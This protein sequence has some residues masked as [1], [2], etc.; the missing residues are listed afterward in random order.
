M[1]I[2]IR[3]LAIGVILVVSMGNADF[4]TS[5]YP[6][7]GDPSPFT[8][9]SADIDK[10]GDLDLAI[11]NWNTGVW[12]FKN[13]GTGNFSHDGTIP[14]GSKSYFIS[15]FDA[16]KDG[17]VDLAVA[18]YGSGDVYVLLNDGTGKYPAN[19][20]DQL[21]ALATVTSV[22]GVDLNN[23]SIVD[24]VATS[25]GT[26]NVITY[27]GQ[28]N[29]SFGPSQTYS[30]GGDWPKGIVSEDVNND[31]F[32]DLIVINK[33]SANVIV[34]INDG[35]GTF[36]DIGPIPYGVGGSPYSITSKD[37]NNDGKPDIITA[38]RDDNN[39]TVL[40][41]NGDGSF[42]SNGSFPTGS[43]P[44]SVISVDLNGDGSY[45]IVSA[46]QYSNNISIL[47]NDGKGSFGSPQNQ[48]AGTGAI[49]VSSGDYNKDGIQDL[50][51]VSRESDDLIVYL[52]KS[53]SILFPEKIAAIERY[54]GS[55]KIFDLSGKEVFFSRDYSNNPENP[56]FTIKNQFRAGVYFL[57]TIN[58]GKVGKVKRTL[59]LK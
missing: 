57:S 48:I 58:N 45:D 56:N 21:N 50:A 7:A 18:N 8:V 6:M 4:V 37:L 53:S 41:N 32:M 26:N 22:I 15:S 47:Y 43:G 1:L 17:S 29:G 34:L 33:N 23:D 42:R 13:D 5:T 31:G 54:H 35:D 38:N 44:R 20:S 11:C 36:G 51:V 52:S 3:Y 27:L 46:N 9:I 59:I 49:S 12:I 14:S 2:K 19:L 30:S 25:G 24:I 10:D 28:T 40:F 16:N 39:V 55:F